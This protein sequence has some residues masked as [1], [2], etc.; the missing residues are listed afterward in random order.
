MNSFI[1][2]SII[3]TVVVVLLAFSP[4][5]FGTYELPKQIF[6]VVLVLVGLLAWVARMVVAERRIEFKRTPLDLPVILFLGAAALSSVF[7]ADRTAS[8]LGSYGRFSDGLPGLLALGAFFFLV[9]NNVR[10]PGFLV[11]P[12]LFSLGIAITASYFAL[13]GFFEQG[14]FP[15]VMR[16]PW[17]N[18]VSGSVK[19]FAVLL[20][21]VVVFLS[22]LAVRLNV[23]QLPRAGHLLFLFS[24]LGLLLMFDATEA[25]AVLLLGLLFLVAGSLAE[26]IAGREK[27]SSGKKLWLPLVL[28]FVSVVF[29]FSPVKVPG[30]P[31]QPPQEPV[32]S[33]QLS[34]GIAWGTATESVKNFLVGSG[35]GTFAID[36]SRHKPLEFNESPLWQARFDRS[37]SH[38]A[39]ILATTGFLGM[40]AYLF[41][42]VW[43]FLASWLLFKQGKS[44]SFVTV[45]VAAFA[46]Q[47]FFYQTTALALAFFLFLALAAL[48]WQDSLKDFTLSLK[49]A[50][51]LAVAS[52][53]LLLGLGAVA[54]AALLF[55]FRFAAAD[56]HY[57]AAKGAP[58][59]DLSLRIEKTLEASLLNPWQAEYKSSLSR[60]Y[61]SRAL[62][63]LRKPDE[64]RNQELISRDVQLAIAF[65]RGDETESGGIKGATELSPGRVA[66]WETMGA[67]YRDISFAEGAADWAIRSFEAAIAL[68]PANPVL[69]T[70]LGKLYV[71]K[72]NFQKAREHFEKAEA[73][74]DD[75]SAAGLQLA[76]LSEK[77]GASET[78][79][80]K[81][82]ALALR[83]PL[84]TEIAFQ[85]GRL[86]YNA[87]R[88]PEAILQ[89]QRILRITPTHSN[90]LFALGVAFER[91]ERFQDAR[92]QFER[93][94]QL[95]PGNEA[96]QEKL[97]QLS[98]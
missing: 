96:V 83:Y 80:S 64:E 21:V 7:S 72:E 30:V 98:E 23:R 63:E 34:W 43:F 3:L 17:F 37:G 12:F 67:V 55:A 94:L 20:S 73:L 71:A 69:Y 85:L 79:V 9:T 53:A 59:S 4:W 56:A 24:A 93:V 62:E 61:S 14:F 41:L 58:S 10:K 77:E 11:M 91:Q 84:D 2:A 18:P 5:T 38:M 57:A 29:L 48:S 78:A 82:R 40:L 66:T 87:G 49:K 32:L 97:R 86:H 88:V 22:S 76:L 13:F 28:L 75:F 16:Q 50:W 31:A 1:K 45:V 74:K 92:T 27:G 95:N 42:A 36:F 89:F 81:L 51:E 33:Q 35:K 70:E 47:L 39:E 25:W 6:L 60:L 8:L 68:E 46:S 90:A 19:G 15:D 54:L 26:G 65:S 52:R 44:L